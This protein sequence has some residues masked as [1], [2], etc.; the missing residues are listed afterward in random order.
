MGSTDAEFCDGGRCQIHE[1]DPRD[2]IPRSSSIT[3]RW[4]QLELV[5]ACGIRTWGCVGRVQ[6]LRGYE[7][8]P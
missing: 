8:E 4:A 5:V 2:V 1:I 7:G 6:S 3:C